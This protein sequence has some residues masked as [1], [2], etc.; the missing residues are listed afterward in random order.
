MAKSSGD[1]SKKA[2]DPAADVLARAKAKVESKDS[3][4]AIAVLG[5]LSA[6]TDCSSESKLEA[7]GL[8]A[9]VGAK[10]AAVAAYLAAGSGFLYDDADM[11]RA[12][13]AFAAAYELEPTSVDVLFQLGQADVVEGRTQDALAKFIDVLRRSN[14]KHLP[15]LFEAGCIYQA[16][17]QHDQAILAFKKVLDKEKGHVQALVHMGQLHQTKGMVPEALGYYVQAADIAREHGQVGTARQMLN[18]VLALDSGNQKARFMLDDLDEHDSDDVETGAAEDAAAPPVAPKPAKTAAP[19]PRQVQPSRAASTAE[20]EKAPVTPAAAHSAPAA[21][22]AEDTAAAER[23]DSLKEEIDSLAAARE[24]LEAELR[25]MQS[26]VDKAKLRDSDLVQS[27]DKERAELKTELAELAG[28]RLTTELELESVKSAIEE[29]RAEREK[30]EAEVAALRLQSDAASSAKA[31]QEAAAQ[32]FE[33]ERARA[34]AAQEA[35]AQAFEAE[36]ARAKAAQEAAAQ[37]FEAERAQARAAQEAA[38]Q[39]FEAERALARAEVESLVA[40]RDEAARARAEQEAALAEI[41]AKRAAAKAEMEMLLAQKAAAEAAIAKA[42]EKSGQ[43]VKAKAEVEATIADLS[44]QQDAAAKAK[45]AEELALAGL[46]ARHARAQA[47]LDALLEKKAAAEKAVAEKTAVEAKVAKT[48]AG[49]EQSVKKLVTERDKLTHE[50]ETLRAQRDAADKALLELRAEEDKS[51]RQKAA[52]EAAIKEDLQTARSE[53]AA[54]EAKKRELDEAYA[55]SKSIAA[56]AEQKR[57]EAMAAA[58]Q[59]EALRAKREADA[60]ALGFKLIALEAALKEADGKTKLIA[61]E[62]ALLEELSAKVGA[63]RAALLELQAARAEAEASLA[64]LRLEIEQAQRELAELRTA[65]DSEVR[66]EPAQQGGYAEAVVGMVP[67]EAC[68][69]A[70]RTIEGLAAEGEIPF[71]IAAELAGLIHEGRAIEALR[72]ARA[73]ANVA[74][75]PAAFLL[76]VGDLS[77]DLGDVERARDAYRTLAEADEKKAAVA[78]ARL[79]ELFLTFADQSTAAALQRD[80]AHFASEKE[81]AKALDTYADLV[82]RFPDDPQFREELGALHEKLGNTVAAGVAYRTAMTL[83]LGSDDY[84]RA[85]ELTPRLLAVCPQDGGVLELAARAQERSGHAADAAHT[86]DLALACYREQHRA[87]DVERVCR[88]LAESVENPVP[89]RKEL[90]GLLAGVGDASGA[91]EQLLEAADTQIRWS[92]G[93]EALTSIKEAE[94]LAKDDPLLAERIATA[95]SKAAEAAKAVDDAS[96]GDLLLSKHEFEKAADAYRRAL[97]ENPYHAG[98]A[99][100]LACILTDQFPDL[101]KAE[102]LLE[103]AATLRPG[104]TATR[105]RLAVVKAARGEIGQA[106]EL[107]VALARFDE[108]NADLIEQFVARLERDADGGSPAAKY[109]LGI[110][111]RELGRVE[112]ALVIL[113]SIQRE[114]EFVVRC[115]NAIGLCLRR[116]GLDTAAAKRFQKAIETPGFPESQYN[117]ALYNL[118]DLYESKT[119]PESLALSL[120]SF[121][122]LYARDCTYRDVADKIRSVKGK[123]GA[124]DGPKVKRLPTRSAESSS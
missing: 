20:P 89:Y 40:R 70:L 65:V 92:Q 91:V 46:E 25:R 1:S 16:N 84:A 8:Y 108:A 105:Y 10:E 115:L 96:R 57:L 37:A 19:L 41:D 22:Q 51:A 55:K 124:V 87:S 7:A 121:E 85:N 50:V 32:A 60:E 45:A 12:R 71:D 9:A 75:L 24:N 93:R 94:A 76:V 38:A 120:S 123:I 6:I 47:E 53:L 101:E 97:E 21:T 62:S 35:A 102:S 17:G 4:G 114:P 82:A 48:S 13:Q 11:T 81:P 52:K 68:G 44:A 14:L 79:G 110:A 61:G 116:Q 18:M 98:A 77:R 26:E 80:D 88:R 117:D 27:A 39:A 36:R 29:L 119:D 104:H 43:V 69:D 23:R 15:A 109:T 31:A 66:R 49:H 58:E 59:A 100:Q 107:L 113:Q 99:Y 56:A 103:T 112:E 42:H 54:T 63:Q 90:A 3:P 5:E 111:Y 83:Y 34:K 73:R 67:P 64:V 95:K 33:A 30:A 78:H 28:Q 74:A 118:G 106:I 122:E 2:A 86:L 72:V